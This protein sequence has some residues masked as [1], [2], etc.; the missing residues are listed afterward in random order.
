MVTY[1]EVVY[2]RARSCYSVTQ[3]K[4]EGI[5]RAGVVSRCGVDDN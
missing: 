3:S 5:S 4:D 2:L 1:V